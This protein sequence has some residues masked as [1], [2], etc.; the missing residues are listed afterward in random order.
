LT[1]PAATMATIPSDVVEHYSLATSHIGLSGLMLSPNGLCVD[2]HNKENYTSVEVGS[3]V[4]PD[5]LLMAVCAPCL[6][7]LHSCKPKDRTT[8]KQVVNNDLG[9]ESEAIESENDTALEP[10]MC[11]SDSGAESD[12]GGILPKISQQEKLFKTSDAV[13]SSYAN[14]FPSAPLRVPQHNYYFQPDAAAASSS[15]SAIEKRKAFNGLPC[16][17]DDSGVECMASMSADTGE[18]LAVT[19][20]NSSTSTGTVSIIQR[21]YKQQY[22]TKCTV[23]DPRKRLRDF[24]IRK[25]CFVNVSPGKKSKNVF[26][27]YLS[28]E[29]QGRSPREDQQCANEQRELIK[30][31]ND[32]L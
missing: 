13:S 16:G 22:S 17:D 6:A 28:K 31:A 3:N 26:N 8:M 4:H 1:V 12:S 21:S 19:D 25:S 20:T 7:V 32:D 2:E 24:R 27:S 5:H 23:Y 15:S 18:S 14:V 11:G 30:S 29:D 10:S 9:D